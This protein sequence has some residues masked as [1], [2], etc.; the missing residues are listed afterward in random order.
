MEVVGGGLRSGTKRWSGE[1]GCQSSSGVSCRTRS[2]RRYKRLA[3]YRVSTVGFV[4][5]L[6]QRRY[7]L[8]LTSQGT[9]S[10]KGEV[11]L[12]TENL[13]AAPLKCGEQ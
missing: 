7:G 10:A 6:A 4:Q 13:R 8:P 2:S 11:L 12:W 9:Q 5:T 1:I 3:I